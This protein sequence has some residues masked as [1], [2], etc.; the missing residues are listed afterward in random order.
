MVLDDRDPCEYVLMG[1][2]RHQLNEMLNNGR[3]ELKHFRSR[4]RIDAVNYEISEVDNDGVQRVLR[5]EERVNFGPECSS[6]ARRKEKL[7][8]KLKLKDNNEEEDVDL[9]ERLPG[10]GG[11]GGRDG[12]STAGRTDVGHGASCGPGTSS[13]AGA[14]HL[15]SLVGCG[16]A[17]AN[18]RT[19]KD[20]ANKKQTGMFS[21]SQGER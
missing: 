9:W 2:M 16:S 11:S 12:D 10:G 5:D 15:S 21:E 4:R 13:G 18:N 17:E 3:I 14:N 19:G 7:K 1:Q 6:N 20:S 8:Q